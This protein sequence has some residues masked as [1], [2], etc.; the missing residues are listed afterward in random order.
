MRN[1]DRIAE[2]LNP[3]PLLAA[4]SVDAERWWSEITLRQTFPGS[5]HH[6]TE[7]IFLRAPIPGPDLQS[8]VESM[9]MPA[10][11]GVMDAA[12]AL[13]HALPLRIAE[14][15]R[16]MVVRLKPG[17]YID[18]HTDE[19]AYAENF[20]RFHIALQAENGNVFHCGQETAHMRTGEAWWFN[21]RVE[22]EVAN[23]SANPRV[24]LIFDA[25]VSSLYRKEA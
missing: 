16:L 21:H 13:I 10:A 22:H 17:G 7:T 9:D 11:D 19:G 2:G 14:L 18:P 4:L 1:F 6:A 15:G 24:H 20:S 8:E 12:M 23:L 5:A 25:R 3:A